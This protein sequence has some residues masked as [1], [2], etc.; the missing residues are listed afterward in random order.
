M[1]VV[2]VLPGTGNI[3]RNKLITVSDMSEATMWKSS[4]SG[5][6]LKTYSKSFVRITKVHFQEFDGRITAGN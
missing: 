3:G 2:D 4:S 1:D 6:L 5:S